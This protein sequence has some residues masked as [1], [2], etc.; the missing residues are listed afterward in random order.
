VEVT[1]T[2]DPG[3]E[4]FFNHEF[5]AMLDAVTVPGY[6]TANVSWDRRAAYLVWTGAKPPLVI[7]QTARP[8]DPVGTKPKSR[9]TTP[10]PAVEQGELFDTTDTYPDTQGVL[11][12]FDANE[13]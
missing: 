1:D 9:R 7:D 4:R 5:Q 8:V 6:G 11:L 10:P 3:F 12:N 2:R 13:V